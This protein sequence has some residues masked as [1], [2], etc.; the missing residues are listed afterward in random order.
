MAQNNGFLKLKFVL[1]NKVKSNR[2][3]P[4]MFASKNLPIAQKKL[5]SL[6]LSKKGLMGCVKD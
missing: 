1:I 6:I 2:N 4:K 5:H 3:L